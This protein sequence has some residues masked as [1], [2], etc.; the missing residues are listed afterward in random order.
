MDLAFQFPSGMLIAIKSLQT[1][2]PVPEI[3]IYNKE[4]PCSNAD[5]SHLKIL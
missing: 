5:R 3:I 1:G 2:R 4:D